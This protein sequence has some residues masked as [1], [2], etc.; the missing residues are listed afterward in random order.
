[1]RS[2]LSAKPGSD[3]KRCIID[4]EIVLLNLLD[5]ASLD[6]YPAMR[7]QYMKTG[8]GFLILYS[9]TSQE[10]LKKARQYHSQ[11]VE[12]KKGGCCAVL[13]GSKCDLA[14]TDRKVTY[15][16]LFRSVISCHYWLLRDPLLNL[17]S[18]R[19]KS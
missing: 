19:V 17:L 9:I 11:I 15:E 4:G 1:L 18:Q 5:T 13:V 3:R 14:S 2:R 16:G 12:V 6:I 8:E 10:S 7:E